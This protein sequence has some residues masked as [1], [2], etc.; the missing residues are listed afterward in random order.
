MGFDLH[1]HDTW[2][3]L[4]TNHVDLVIEMTN[5]Y[6]NS[7]VL[8]LSHMVGHD[9]FLVSSG[10]NEYITS[11]DAN[12]ETLHSNVDRLCMLISNLMTDH[13]KRA[14]FLVFKANFKLNS[15]IRT[16]S[17]TFIRFFANYNGLMMLWGFV[18]PFE[19][20]YGASS[21]QTESVLFLIT[22]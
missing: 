17:P 3:C 7:V 8:H 22:R 9:D 16:C 6:N 19:S 5:T 14:Q 12:L 15:H 1:F 13:H 21:N 18:K 2:I 20:K 11:S 10:G 4:N